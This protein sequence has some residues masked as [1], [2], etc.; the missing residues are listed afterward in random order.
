MDNYNV[1]F[2]NHDGIL[3]QKDISQM[4]EMLE[5]DMEQNNINMGISANILTIFIE[6]SQNI[7]NY[8]KNQDEDSEELSPSG[9][10]LVSKDNQCNYY[11]QSQNIVS[12]TDK[13]K[14]E[15][16]LTEIESL[17]KAGIKARYKELRRSGKNTHDKGG[18]IGFYE[19]AKR[20][21]KIKHDFM[22][23]N[24]SKFVFHIKTK[25]STQKE[26]SK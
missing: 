7:L 19:I 14:M 3:S 16:K 17:D 21:D 2:I 11:I 23:L 24:P 15:H 18:G 5:E 20:C 22:K 10:I 25:V 8:S 26:S 4:T 1:V 12:N 9:L 6:L 13:D